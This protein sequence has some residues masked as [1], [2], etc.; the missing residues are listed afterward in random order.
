MNTTTL[1]KATSLRIDRALYS[2]IERL[3]KAQNRSVNNFIETTLAD[4]T[5][6]HEP[7]EATIQAI[8]EARA[9]RPHLKGYTDMDELFADLAK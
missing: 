6:F 4:A 3:A 5:N 1:K 7:N 9:E 8:A 2:Y